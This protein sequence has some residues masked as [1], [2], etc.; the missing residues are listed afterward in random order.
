MVIS[1]V[2]GMTILMRVERHSWRMVI[3]MSVGM[4]APVIA[5]FML[6][7]FGVSSSVPLLGWLT[8]ANLYTLA[9]D[10]MLLG[11]VGV[12]VV[13]RGM[14]ASHHARIATEDQPPS[15]HIDMPVRSTSKAAP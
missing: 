4:V 8:N 3:E 13:R 1:M 5:L 15:A 7:R 14:Y 2:A 10:G 6:V 9:H 12:M 11:M